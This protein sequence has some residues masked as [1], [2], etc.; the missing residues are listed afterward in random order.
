MGHCEDLPVTLM[1]KIIKLFENGCVS[2]CGM[3]GTG[4]DVLTG[5][6]IMRR[7]IPY[8]SNMYYGGARTVLDFK[9]LDCG[10]NSYKNFISGDVNYYDWPYPDGTDIYI[11]DAGL[12]LPAQYCNELNKLYP[13]LPNIFALIRQLGEGRIHVNSQAIQRVWDKFREQSDT[14]IL[15]KWVI[16]PFI[17][18]FGI[19]VQ[20][21]YIY[22]RYDSC[23]SRVPPFRVPRPWMNKDRQ[24]QWEMAKQNYEIAHGRIQSR[25]LI[26]KNKSKHDTRL[27]KEMLLNGKKQN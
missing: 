24:F 6:V 23:A 2:V 9:T 20:R 15:C 18:W 4:K 26:Y 1:K 21:V 3:M 22:E 14:Y 27:F 16:K 12:Y 10:C 25:L 19:V 5:N 13:H 8:V 17:K 7:Q 11:S